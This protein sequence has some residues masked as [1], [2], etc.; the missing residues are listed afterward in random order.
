M[1]EVMKQRAMIFLGG[2]VVGGLVAWSLMPAP[3][4]SKYEKD[5]RILKFVD[6]DLRAYSESKSPQEKIH[7]ADV[8]YQK[9]VQLFVV[10]LDMKVQ[11]LPPQA[12]AS[13]APLPDPSDELAVDEGE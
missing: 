6:Q 2:I 7:Q 8:L 1:N 11:G 13:S 3:I 5:E 4:E 10:E 9:A 12:P